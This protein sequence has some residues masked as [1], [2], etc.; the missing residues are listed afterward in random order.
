MEIPSDLWAWFNMKGDA[1]AL[2]AHFVIGIIIIFLIECGLFECL[3]KIT[4]RT[5]PPE[6]E[7]LE[8]DEDVV[9]EIE[10][11]AR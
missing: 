4:C 2:I 10:R 1:A 11:I 3:A 8:L 9:N 6:N 7:D 5:M